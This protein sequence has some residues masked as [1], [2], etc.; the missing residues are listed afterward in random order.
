MFHV[1]GNLAPQLYLR[2]RETAHIPFKYQSFSVGQLAGTQVGRPVVHQGI[3]PRWLSKGGEQH[4]TVLG[5][6]VTHF[7]QLHSLFLRE[8]RLQVRCELFLV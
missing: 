6:P 5:V 3:G 7:L 8:H 1:Q 2:P 4:L